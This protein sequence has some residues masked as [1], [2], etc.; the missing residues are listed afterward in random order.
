MG[1]PRA[2]TMTSLAED[3]RRWLALVVMV[4]AGV[5]VASLWLPRAELSSFEDFYGTYGGRLGI[6]EGIPADARL[7]GL[8]GWFFPVPAAGQL[9]LAGLAWQLALVVR[10]RPDRVI[11][12]RAFPL[13]AAA[14]G[15]ALILWILGA[16]VFY[17]GLDA[18][19]MDRLAGTWVAAG[20]GG[21]AGAVLLGLAA[22]TVRERR[23]QSGQAGSSSRT[24][25]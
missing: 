1:G 18:P 11:D 23:S 15:S 21:T 14:V 8:P 6:P 3:R 25:A 16:V 7:D 2:W 5:L 4:G 10:L 17:P 22:D 12:D 9:L 20:S 19:S 13:K 24:R